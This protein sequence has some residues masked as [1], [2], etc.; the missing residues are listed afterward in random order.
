M[1]VN[2]WLVSIDLRPEEK[3]IRQTSMELPSKKTSSI[4]KSSKGRSARRM[5]HIQLFRSK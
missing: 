5:L 3:E 4:E 2:L 1:T